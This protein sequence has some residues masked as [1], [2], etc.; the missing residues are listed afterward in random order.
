[1]RTL[2]ARG[3][4]LTHLPT[5]GIEQAFMTSM[6]SQRSRRVRASRNGAPK[7]VDLRCG[8]AGWMYKDWEGI[9]YPRPK[10]SGFD[11]LRYIA[12]FFDAVEIN[13]SFYGPPLATTSSNWVR[14]VEDNPSFRFTAKLWK[15]FT[16]ERSK[17]WT[18]AD[19]DQVRAGFDITIQSARR[20]M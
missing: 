2:G 5:I 7:A 12:Q 9:V 13:S 1:M 20:L 18:T 6:S 4:W 11:Q 16:H 19:V 3:Y 10:P 14:R 17:A 15:R 8:P